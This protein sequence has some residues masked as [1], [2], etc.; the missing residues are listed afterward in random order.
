MVLGHIID[1]ALHVSFT[2]V[3]T[4]QGIVK[5]GEK[6]MT[7]VFKELK[8]LHTDVMDGKPIVTSVDPS[9][10]TCEEKINSD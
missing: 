1:K 9:T 2:H 7:T 10:L 3:L 5:H 8:Q 4:K 6:A